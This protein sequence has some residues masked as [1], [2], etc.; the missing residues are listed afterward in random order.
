MVI[1]VGIVKGFLFCAQNPKGAKDLN[2]SR[3]LVWE[4][5]FD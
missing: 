3:P 2:P 4:I 1:V 5:N